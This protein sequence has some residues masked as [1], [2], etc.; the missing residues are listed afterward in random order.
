MQKLKKNWLFKK[1]NSF[2]LIFLWF[3]LTE[4]NHLENAVSVLNNVYSFETCN[5]LKNLV[6]KFLHISLVIISFHYLTA[7]EGVSAP[8]LSPSPILCVFWTNYVWMV[9]K[10]SPERDTNNGVRLKR[11]RSLCEDTGTVP[12]NCVS[13]QSEVVVMVRPLEICDNVT[14]TMATC[15]KRVSSVI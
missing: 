2:S 7:H 14:N 15:P 1:F 10:W 4:R 8:P 3:N 9:G 11:A 13:W 6:L 12:G 5:K